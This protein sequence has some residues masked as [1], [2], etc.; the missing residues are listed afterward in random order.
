MQVA[1]EKSDFL[2][3]GTARALLKHYCSIAVAEEE[4]KIMQIGQEAWR[5]FTIYSN[6]SVPHITQLI[7]SF[8]PYVPIRSH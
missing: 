5:I 7:K 4:L 2:L 1:P 8:I 6:L 3:E